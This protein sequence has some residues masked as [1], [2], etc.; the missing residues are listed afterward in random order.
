MNIIDTIY[1]FFAWWH[2]LI[3]FFKL[4]DF[5]TNSAAYH[6]N[7]YVGQDFILQDQEFPLVFW[8]KKKCKGW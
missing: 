7:K 5:F 4:I 1:F 3:C 8:N 2:V 6:L